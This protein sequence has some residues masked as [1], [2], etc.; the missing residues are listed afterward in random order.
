MSL[1]VKTEEWRKELNPEWGLEMRSSVGR[2]GSGDIQRGKEKEDE[3]TIWCPFDSFGREGF[4]F[5]PCDILIS[6][7]TMS[8]DGW[9]GRSTQTGR[10]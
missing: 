1:I 5:P 8:E 6:L 10:N 4:R 7:R 9:K 3:K 2:K